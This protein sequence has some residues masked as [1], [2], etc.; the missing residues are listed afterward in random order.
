VVVD[1]PDFFSR[2]VTRVRRM[3]SHSPNNLEV[4]ARVVAVIQAFMKKTK[5]AKH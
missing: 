3:F 5:K 4:V 2:Q 1:L